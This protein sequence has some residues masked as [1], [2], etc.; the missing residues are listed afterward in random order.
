MWIAWEKFYFNAEIS[1]PW[2]VLGNAFAGDIKLIQWYEFTGSLGGSLWI[3]LS[4][5][6][7]FFILINSLGDNLKNIGWKGTVALYGS[8]IIIIACPIVLSHLIYENYE[9]E[10]KGKVEVVIAQPNFDPYQKF[11]SLSQRQQN[12]ILMDLMRKGLSDYDSTS[13]N[14]LLL[15]APETF[16][17]D[18]ALNDIKESATWQSF[19]AFLQDFPRANLLFGASTTEFIYN[20]EAPSNTARK[21]RD[22]IWYQTY[23]SALMTDYSGRTDI[24]HKSKL[25]VGVE[26]TP[27][28]AV[29][30]KIDDM[31]GGVMGRNIGQE[32]ISLLN[33]NNYNDEGKITSRI[34]VGCAICYESVYGDYC[35]DYVKKGARAMTIIT[36]DSWWG[37]TP[38][39]RQHF[40][41]ARLRAIELRRDIA[42][43]GNSGISAFIN[44]RGD[45]VQK[46]EWW[47]R[48]FLKGEISLNDKQTFFV[49]YGD[50]V[51]RIC[52]FV[53][54]LLVLL[55][56]VR[57]IIRR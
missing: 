5:I 38:G 4:N 16:T 50:V 7:L 40:R 2:L 6:F 3:W 24:F 27:Y 1:W 35:R 30:T 51:G 14:A 39:Y 29:F 41:Y 20:D 54:M 44:Q 53:F 19:N 12:S 32:E 11:E 31:L 52:S 17:G 21:L 33:I 43:C 18:I 36:N 45:V 56:F 46:S 13:N 26:K 9:E 57:A 10:S 47:Q 25:V 23:N 55:L 15:L 34:P 42:R 8:F 49:R 22:S 28:P 48:E 37:N